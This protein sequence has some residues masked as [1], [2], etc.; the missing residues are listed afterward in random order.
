MTPAQLPRLS[1]QDSQ[2]VALA[3]AVS[4]VLVTGVSLLAILIPDL[5]QAAQV[6][7]VG[8]GNAV[9]ILGGAIYAIR[10]STPVARPVVEPGTTVVVQTPPDEENRLVTV[11]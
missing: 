1:V 11:R 8:F 7:L 10:K 2:P 3:A 5:S 6:G 9:I 4:G